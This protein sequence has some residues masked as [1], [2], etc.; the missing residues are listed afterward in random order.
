MDDVKLFSHCA[1]NIIQDILKIDII[2]PCLIFDYSNNP[3]INQGYY[4]YKN[5][6]NNIVLN[7]NSIEALKDLNDIKTVITYG[8]IHEI[9]HMFQNINSYYFTDSIYYNIVEDTTDKDTINIITKN[10]NL[11]ES[12]LNFKF[13]DVFLKGIDRQL[14]YNNIKLKYNDI[15]TKKYNFNPVYFNYREY[16]CNI[17]TQLLCKGIN[18]NYDYIKNILN[19]ILFMRFII[20]DFNFTIDLN[21]Y[22][23]QDLKYIYYKLSLEKIKMFSYSIDEGIRMI[24]FKIL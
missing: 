1:I 3:N 16:T 13:N 12:E 14:I 8:F 7:M 10:L 20:D 15:N 23:I 6:S 18:I 17:I 2:T 5:Y 11:I 9:L 24:I 4:M 22:N 21:N 19:N